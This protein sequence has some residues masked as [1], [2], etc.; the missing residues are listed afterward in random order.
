MLQLDLIQTLTFC[1][2]ALTGGPGTALVDDGV[3]AESVQSGGG[4]EDDEEV[5]PLLKGVIALI[6]NLDDYFGWLG[7]SHRAR[8]A[9]RRWWVR[10]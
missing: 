10:S 5:F 7:L 3:E 4:A 1:G 8:S 2:V 9:L 6:R